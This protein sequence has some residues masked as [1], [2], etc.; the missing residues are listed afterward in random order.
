MRDKERIPKFCNEL[1]SVWSKSFCDWRFSQ[2]MLNFL[3]WLQNKTKTDGF[4]I[5]DDKMLEYIKEYANENSMW[6]KDN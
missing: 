3:G 6:F 5:E 2:F 4:Y 1:S